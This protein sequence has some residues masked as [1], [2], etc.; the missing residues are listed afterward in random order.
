MEQMMVRISNQEL[1]WH[2]TYSAFARPEQLRLKQQLRACKLKCEFADELP[3]S[4]AVCMLQAL[5]K[6]ADEE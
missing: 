3:V 6:Q 5:R 4:D 1:N 2:D